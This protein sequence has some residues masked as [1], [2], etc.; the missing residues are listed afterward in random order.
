MF[1][2]HTY[3]GHTATPGARVARALLLRRAGF[4]RPRACVYRAAYPRTA[5]L[6]TAR[7]H[8][9]HVSECVSPPRFFFWKALTFVCWWQFRSG[10]E[11]RCRVMRMKS[12]AFRGASASA[13]WSRSLHPQSNRKKMTSG[14]SF[15]AVFPP[16][17]EYLDVVSTNELPGVVTNVSG[18]AF[19]Q[20]ELRLV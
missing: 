20:D 3:T 6:P 10:R 15:V 12:E 1:L 9:D 5:R 18:T 14:R 8:T 13:S 19:S 4:H 11:D 2:T 7:T 17:S 16:S